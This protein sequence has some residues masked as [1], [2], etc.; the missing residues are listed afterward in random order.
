MNNWGKILYSFELEYLVGII[1]NIYT[2]FQRMGFS[3]CQRL[4]A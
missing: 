3:P 2:L 4:Q 1:S